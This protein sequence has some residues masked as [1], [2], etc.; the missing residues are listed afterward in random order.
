MFAQTLQ[1]ILNCVSPSKGNQSGEGVTDS[2]LLERFLTR[3]DEA[4]FE[5]LVRRHG[6]LV[7][8]ICRRLLG[9]V[10]DVEDAF[11]ATF[12]VLTRKASSIGK[13]D[14]ISSWLY[15]VA[16]RIAL[17]ARK[18]KAK[19]VNREKFLAE[20][21]VPERGPD[22]SNNSDWRELQPVLDAEINRLPEK[23]RAVLVLCYLEGKT[24]EA[25]A[26]ELGC[27]KGTVLSRLARGRDRLRNRLQQRGITLSIAPFA[28][29][30]AQNARAWAEV[31]PQL[32]H[33]TTHLAGFLAVSQVVARSLAVSVQDLVEEVIQDMTRARRTRRMMILFIL[34]GLLSSGISVYAC[35]TQVSPSRASARCPN[36]P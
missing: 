15:K 29:V 14:S 10:H 20:L 1:S 36:A 3:R 33:A 32:I 18:R 12:L 35:V 26:Q 11:Q 21:D 4:A 5:L 16:Y 2:E 34:L 7:Y 22:F 8:G 23:Y 9:N 24:N 27:P 13:R 28:L 25:A 30:L 17:R 19:Q 31:S 6:A